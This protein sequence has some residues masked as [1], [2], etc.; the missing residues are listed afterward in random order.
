MNKSQMEIRERDTELGTM[1]VSKP[2]EV[3]PGEPETAGDDALP[4]RSLADTARNIS[5]CENEEVR[6]LSYQKRR[7][8]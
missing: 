5:P 1:V 8:G 3:S 6:L 2:K 7:R 4:P